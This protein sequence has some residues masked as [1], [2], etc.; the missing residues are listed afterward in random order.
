M[1]EPTEVERRILAYIRGAIADTGEA[2]TVREIAAGVGLRSPST[3]AY[4]LGRLEEGGHLRR[5]QGRHRSIRL[6]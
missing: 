6:T 4:H 5:E 1:R 3:V 2:P